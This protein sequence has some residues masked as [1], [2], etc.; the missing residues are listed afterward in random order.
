MNKPAKGEPNCTM[1]H[2]PNSDWRIATIVCVTHEGVHWKG[3]WSVEHMGLFLFKK[4]QY[5]NTS[6]LHDFQNFVLWQCI[7]SK[8][9]CTFAVEHY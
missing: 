6:W 1:Q 4:D 9:Y 8:V 3:K 5:F 2:N 7:V